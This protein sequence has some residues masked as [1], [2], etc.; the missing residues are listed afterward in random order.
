MSA[1][2]NCPQTDT[3]WSTS[4][5]EFQYRI[6]PLCGHALYRYACWPTAHLYQNTLRH[7][8][9]HTHVGCRSTD[10]ATLP[11]GS[12]LPSNHNLELV[13]VAMDRMA[14]VWYPELDQRHAYAYDPDLHRYALYR[15]V[16]RASL[17]ALQPTAARMRMGSHR[18]RAVHAM[19]YLCLLELQ[20]AV[21]VGV[22]CQ[23][24]IRVQNGPCCGAT[25]TAMPTP[26]GCNW[27]TL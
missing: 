8:N 26:Q 9:M 7:T 4:A 23:D 22:H 14:Y 5:I 25:R 13:D 21:H 16:I 20:L 27:T 6:G 18:I 19:A 11:P 15:T 3:P 17:D 24:V 10:C 1:Y 2:W 12:E